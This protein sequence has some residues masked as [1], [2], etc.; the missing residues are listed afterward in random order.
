MPPRKAMAL[1][2]ENG[3]GVAVFSPSSKLHWNFGPHRDGLSDDPADGPCMHV[4]PI[5][6][7]MMG[8]KSTYRYR[9]WLV[10]GDESTIATNL[11][12]LWKKYSA[13]G[14]QITQPQNDLGSLEK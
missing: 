1:L 12:A 6:R 9:Y 13:E 8:P 2:E 4:A 11:D 5:D 7:V 3:Q 10:V 14:A